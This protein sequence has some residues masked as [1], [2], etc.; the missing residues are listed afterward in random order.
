M[1]SAPRSFSSVLAI[2]VSLGAFSSLVVL[3]VAQQVVPE[4][5]ADLAGAAHHTAGLLLA[6][7]GGQAAGI[8][9]AQVNKP[10]PPASRGALAPRP[11][12]PAEAPEAAEMIASEPPEAAASAPPEVAAASGA[13]RIRPRPRPAPD[14][15]A[16]RVRPVRRGRILLQPA[17]RPL[18][19]PGRGL[20][21]AG[22]R[23]RG[24]AEQRGVRREHLQRRPGLLQRQLRHLRRA[25]GHLQPV[26]L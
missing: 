18:R 24:L 7:P 5:V 3:G 13:G 26:P 12:P 22:L 25:R 23:L 9:P 10:S 14:P 6:R 8:A 15:G 11:P 20:R 16:L 17:L 19:R 1:S 4:L 2:A 21:P